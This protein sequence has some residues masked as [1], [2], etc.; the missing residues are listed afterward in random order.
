MKVYVNGNI[1]DGDKA[2]I[3]VFDRGFLYGD[4]I[5]ETIRSYNGR[6]FRAKDHLG[7]LYSTLKALKIKQPI[8]DKEAERV[9]YELLEINGLK[10]ARIRITISRGESEGRK[11]DISKSGAPTI[12]I[13]AEQ[14]VPPPDKYYENGIA[15]D[16]AEARRNSR[17]VLKNLKIV[18]YLDN[19]LARNEALPKGCFDTIFLTDAGYV[20]EGSTS[21]VFMVSGNKLL[22]PSLDCGVLPGITRKVIL[23]ISRYAGLGM[24]EGKFILEDLEN[25][26]EVFITNSLFEILP[27]VKVEENIIGKG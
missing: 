11:M 27:V 13:S 4:A 17:T 16:I 24:Q 12:V 15:V 19:I 5:F 26:S 14:Y 21:N 9:V 6:L 10:D 20:C 18:N 2:F 23:E 1:V 8:A 7:R 22:T 3:S 25:A